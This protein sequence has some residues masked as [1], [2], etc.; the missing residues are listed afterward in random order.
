MLILDLLLGLILYDVVLG[1]ENCTSS[2]YLNCE[3]IN[4]VNCISKDWWCD[5]NQDCESGKDES[6][7]PPKVCLENEFLCHSG[8]QCIP[9]LLL[10]DGTFHCV[11]KSDERNCTKH[12]IKSCDSISQF[13]CNKDGEICIPISEVCDKKNNCGRN[14]D[15]EPGNSVDNCQRNDCKLIPNGGCSHFCTNFFTYI[16]CHCPL[17]YKLQPDNR[18][19]VDIDECSA[20]PSKCNQICKNTPGSYEC[21]CYDGY[22]QNQH[23]S[24]Y[25]IT[26]EGD[27][28]ILITL[29]G[30][31]QLM[32]DLNTGS[33]FYKPLYNSHE[34]LV[35]IDVD[36]HQSPQTMFWI[37]QSNGKLGQSKI[38]LKV[39][40]IEK[41][42]FL[43]HKN[44]SDDHI[45]Q[46]CT[47]MSFDWLRGLLFWTSSIE[48]II[49][50]TNTTSNVTSV[51]L[52]Q[53]LENPRSIAVDPINT[54]VYWIDLGTKKSSPRIEMMLMNTDNRRV[55]VSKNLRQP[56]DLLIDLQE[57]KLYWS[58]ID[59]GSINFINL[60]T[61]NNP[62]TIISNKLLYPFSIAVF[63]NNI[64]WT[65]WRQNQIISI[66]KITS[67]S[68]T[69]L[70]KVVKPL[71]IQ[72]L[73]KVIQPKIHESDVTSHA[74]L[75]NKM[76]GCS[77][78]CLPFPS[79][80]INPNEGPKYKCLCPKDSK[81]QGDKL[82]C[83]FANQDRQQKITSIHSKRLKIILGVSISLLFILCLSL[84]IICVY[85][86]RHRNWA[87]SNKCFNRRAF[88]HPIVTGD[89][90]FIFK[91]NSHSSQLSELLASD[92]SS[93]ATA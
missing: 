14:Q 38:D 79:N 10:C 39:N 13:D 46:L 41:Y 92:V 1:N 6:N 7:C 51:L 61:P 27:R 20:S 69:V 62:K 8:T 19:C 58:D 65:D 70:A 57:R 50:V 31:R 34:S 15:E 40:N 81:L 53:G 75:K 37:Q 90:M 25:C 74:C 89:L 84:T 66:D 67:D 71:A 43:N 52:N 93:T 44:L 24:E 21:S 22:R 48:K 42:R 87:N 82:T 86:C 2:D 45:G 4:A 60:D 47:D 72:V 5:G 35:N 56:L 73:N 76:H 33:H 3:D 36:L 26:K 88:N 83:H 29:N 54:G 49:Y 28:S 55:L 17:G 9:K 91:C 12:E 78:I 16:K 11:D 68:Y 64:F 85:A 80:S 59:P 63:E 77:H 18:T 30:G 32:I 23:N